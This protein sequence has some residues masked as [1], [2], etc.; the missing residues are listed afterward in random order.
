M[1]YVGGTMG[2]LIEN[3]RRL[4]VFPYRTVLIMASCFSVICLWPIQMCAMVP[5]LLI[6]LAHLVRGLQ[7]PSSSTTVRFAPGIHSCDDMRDW[8]SRGPAIAPLGC[9]PLS[10]G[11]PSPPIRALCNW[12]KLLIGTSCRDY[13]TFSYILL[14]RIDQKLSRGASAAST[15]CRLQPLKWKCPC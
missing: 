10:R 4:Y 5:H 14:E 6:N 13:K 15:R 1:G 9:I 3:A 7:Y 2:A 8:T 11:Y 12:L